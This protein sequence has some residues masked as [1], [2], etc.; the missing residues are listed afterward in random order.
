MLIEDKEKISKNP[1][2]SVKV[3]VYN[4]DKYLRQCF[5]SILSQRVNF[6]YEIIVGEDCS[7]DKSR[8][9]CIE[10]QQKYP[11]LIRL[12]LHEKNL[13]LIGNCQSVNALHRGKYLIL[14]GGDDYFC[15]DDKFQMQYDYMETHSDVGLC[16]TNVI[17]CTEEGKEL[18]T[19]MLESEI[20]SICFEDQLI[21]SKYFGPNTWMIR[22]SEFDRLIDMQSW[23]VDES[24]ATTLDFL[25][26]SKL[27]FI[28][29][30]TTVYRSRENSLSSFRDIQRRW[31]YESGIYVMQMYYAK[32][33]AVSDAV[34]DKIKFTVFTQ[35]LLLAV[36]ADDK[37]F[38][39]EALAFYES[40][41]YDMTWYAENCREYV[42][43]KRLFEQLYSSRAYR[44]G[45]FLLKPLTW[46]NNIIHG[47]V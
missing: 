9:I 6:E 21:N 43:T 11:H 38:V 44:L 12:V 18:S 4:S 24:L 14:L 22:R 7:T 8:Q 47:R 1:Q 39:A 40:K 28:D 32:K 16:F 30:V 41:G 26:E 5:D 37:E 31:K 10:Y 42:K 17:Q 34:V 46:L 15:A 29:K 25:H 33:Y 45:K 3:L 35:S 27:H 13:G 36:D 2:L 20:A 23:F 19:P